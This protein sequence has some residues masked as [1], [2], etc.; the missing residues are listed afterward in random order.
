M[1]KV[2]VN[3]YNFM[4]YIKFMYARCLMAFPDRNEKSS[5][6]PSIERIINY[7]II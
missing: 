7:R 1:F 3:I 4:W 2:C 5:T 6:N